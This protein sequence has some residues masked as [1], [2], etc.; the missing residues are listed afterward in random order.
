MRPIPAFRLIVAMGYPWFV[1]GIETKP[2]DIIMDYRLHS[3]PDRL[4][5]EPPVKETLIWDLPLRLFHWSMV[6]VV[7]VAALTGFF[8]P[9]GWLDVHTVAGYALSSLLAFR[10]AWGFFG[11]HFSKF[12]TF[13]LSRD[14]VIKHLGQIIA[15]KSPAHIGHNPTGALMIV[16][17]LL[18]LIAVVLTGLVTLGGQEKLGPLAFITSYK[19]GHFSKELHEMAAFAVVGAIFIHLFGVF[20]ETRVFKH[21]VI[22]AMVTGKKVTVGKFLIPKHRNGAP[23]GVILSLL[24]PA[25]L[26]AGGTVLANKTPAGWKLLEIPA[27]YASEC[28]DCHSAYHPSLRSAGAWQAVMAGLPDH[29]GEDA[30]LGQKTAGRISAFLQANS[31]TTFDTKVARRVGRNDT[32]SLRM[33]DTPFWKKRHDEIDDAVFRMRGVGS[34]VNCNACHKDAMSG[35]FGDANIHVPTGDK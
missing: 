26:I 7:T 2:A 20:V 9:V 22:Q 17:L 18:G 34:K 23:R 31:A 10:L 24:V 30:S 33:T 27:V 25:V 15:R 21:R 6:C 28:G 13:P 1:V 8:A 19:I 32:K 12:K 5:V 29:F 14:R 16:V 35:R 4:A 3:D 11:G